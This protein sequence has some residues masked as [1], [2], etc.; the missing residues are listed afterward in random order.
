MKKILLLVLVLSAL[1]GFWF[2]LKADRSPQTVQLTNMP[3][4]VEISPDGSSEVF[5]IQLMQT[6]LTDLQLAWG[7]LQPEFGLFTNKQQKRRLEVYLGK[8]RLGR[9]DARIILAL[10]AEDSV[11]AEFSAEKAKAKPMPSGDYR[12]GLSESAQTRAMQMPIRAI[13]YI[14]SVQYDNELLERFFGMPSERIQWE[15]G[16][17]FWLYPERGLVVLVDQ[18][19]KEVF[20]YV[21]PAEFPALLEQLELESPLEKNAG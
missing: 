21:R 17:S 6:T 10:A 3:W 4:Q 13:T 16:T 14:P 1:V 2:F 15:A 19:G 7:G 11:L 12:Q 20:H 8:R 5:G 18:E 9:F